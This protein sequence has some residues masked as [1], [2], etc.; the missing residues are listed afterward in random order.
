MP[1]E[2]ERLPEVHRAQLFLSQTERLVR[3]WKPMRRRQAMRQQLVC[4]LP[5]AGPA[6]P[7]RSTLEE[8]IQACRG[9]GGS[10]SNAWIASPFFDVYDESSRITVALCKSMARGHRRSLTFCVPAFRDSDASAVIR[11]AAPRALLVTPTALCLQKLR[12]SMQL[13][14]LALR[15]QLAVL[16]RRTRTRPALRT[17]D[18]LFWVSALT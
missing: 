14:I 6:Q 13:E 11:L 9:R 3:G 4:T 12:A 5:A 8:T 18:R 2:T 17:S 10:P 15:H 7:A 1:G 16:Q